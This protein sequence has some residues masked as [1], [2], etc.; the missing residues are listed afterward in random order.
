MTSVD[1]TVSPVLSAT[2]PATARLL[3]T[4]TFRGR[5]RALS[6]CLLQGQAC[7]QRKACSLTPCPLNE[8]FVVQQKPSASSPFLLE[9]PGQ[10]LAR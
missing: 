1:V 3:S 5:H 4:L 10:E 8:D 2:T 9:L 7:T 6:A